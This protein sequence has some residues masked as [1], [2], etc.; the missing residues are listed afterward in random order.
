M[1]MKL[2]NKDLEELIQEK[3]KELYELKKEYR[4]KK[5]AGLR[6]AMEAKR[7]AEKMIREEMKS[8]DILT[9]IVFTF[10]HVDTSNHH[11]MEHRNSSFVG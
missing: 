11:S 7:E 5:T 4:E 9:F 3:E 10:S 6:S 2:D 1:N 8:L